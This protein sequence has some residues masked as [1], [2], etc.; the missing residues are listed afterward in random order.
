MPH[1][2]PHDGT[3]RIMKELCK[4]ASQCKQSKGRGTNGYR[5]HTPWRNFLHLSD[6]ESAAS[7]THAGLEDKPRRSRSRRDRDDN[8]SDNDDGERPDMIGAEGGV[9]A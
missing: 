5:I 8:D 4:Y 2:S 1:Q 6:S 9:F 3:V 7:V